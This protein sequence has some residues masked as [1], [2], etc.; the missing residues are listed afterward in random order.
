VDA[1]GFM[2]GW[3]S[4]GDEEG[5]L[6]RAYNI[7]NGSI[8]YLYSASI[9]TLSSN[10]VFDITYDG[11]MF[12][13]YQDDVLK[14]DLFSPNDL[15]M[16]LMFDANISGSGL[17]NIWYGELTGSAGN[18]IV[19]NS[20]SIETSEPII[21]LAFGITPF[22]KSWISGS[23]PNYGLVAKFSDD[24]E[25]NH[26][27]FGLLK[28]FSRNTHTVFSPVVVAK[29]DDSVY[30]TGSWT[31]ASSDALT[32]FPVNLRPEYKQGEVVRVDIVAR[33]LYPMKTFT[34]QFEAWKNRYLPIT[35]Y[36]SIVDVQSQEVIIPFDEY[37]KISVDGD[38]NYIMFAVD[39]MFPRRYYKLMFKVI[40]P[41]GHRYIFDEHYNFTVA[42]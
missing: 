5:D 35:S 27:N 22:I 12:R 38:G 23:I 1:S 31:S 13:Y 11:I 20:A 39:K 7:Q 4:L 3:Y 34:T 16:Q 41:D 42:L 32:V 2:R 26:N 19:Y 14:A 6:I 24:T 36:Y 29:W 15:N 8:T 10:T 30:Q 33:E 17:T 37:S 9:N 25:A 18:I 40:F 21:D 28:F